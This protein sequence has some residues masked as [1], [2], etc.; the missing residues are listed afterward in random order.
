[1]SDRYRVD[2]NF[3]GG[4][5]VRQ[6][7]VVEDVAMGAARMTGALVGIGIGGVGSLIRNNRDRK[8]M[9]AVDR[10]YEAESRGDYDEMLRLA[11]TFSQK[12]KQEPFGPIMVGMALS[13]KGQHRQALA[14]LDTAAR[15][16]A[17]PLDLVDFRLSVLMDMEDTA[18]ALRECATLIQS[19]DR[20]RDGYFVRALSLVRLGDLAQ[21]LDDANRVITLM[22]DEDAYCLRGDVYREMEQ[23]QDALQ[24]YTRAV[25]LAPDNMTLL[26][27]RAG[28][29]ERLGKDE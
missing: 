4:Y 8:A 11:T 28:M 3:T 12:Y 22:P 26:E 29:Y 7:D 9:E 2:R 6:T 24:D 19:Q 5:T 23:Y 15:L 13:G 21:A 25:R 18:G 20:Q 1:M 14:S 27:S 16:G 17:T 10:I